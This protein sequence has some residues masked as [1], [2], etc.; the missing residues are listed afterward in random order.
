MGWHSSRAPAA[1]CSCDKPALQLFDPSAY[2]VL[3]ASLAL[4]KLQWSLNAQRGLSKVISDC[5]GST[6]PASHLRF[7]DNH[8]SAEIQSW[9]P[10]YFTFKK[11]AH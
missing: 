5:L 2:S 11:L 4:Y 9:L 3:A 8:S 10:G 1:H 6:K 7:S